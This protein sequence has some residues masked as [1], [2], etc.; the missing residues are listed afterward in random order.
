MEEFSSF[1]DV[2]DKELNTTKT[3]KK[4]KKK[5]RISNLKKGGS[6]NKSSSRC[7]NCD[8]HNVFIDTQISHKVCY[9]C[10][11]MVKF[12]VNN[13]A[14]WRFYGHSDDNKGKDPSRCGMPLDT[15][16]TK[17][18]MTTRV[19]CTNSKYNSLVR[20]QKWQQIH[21]EERPLFIVFTFIDKVLANV[22]YITDD[23]KTLAK[24]YYKILSKPDNIRG[25]LTRG[26]SRKSFIGA[27]IYNAC[28]NLGIPVQ[29]IE[30]AR[31]LDIETSDL[32]RGFKKFAQ[33]EKQKGIQ[34]NKPNCSMLHNYIKKFAN[35]MKFSKDMEDLGH[36]FCLRF[37]KLQILTDQ[38]DLSIV[39]GLLF[40]LT[41]AFYNTHTYKEK[42]M[43]VVNVSGVTLDKVYKVIKENIKYL[44]IGL[45]G[46]FEVPDL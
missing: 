32:T 21:H 40:Y 34:L 13:E 23:A 33:L 10:G 42:I 19:R 31:L 9:D 18:S 6:I 16:L 14:E 27:C 29:K 46:H 28:K 3:Q 12:I 22:E 35:E 5:K 44:Y 45:E 15:L 36:L 39:S 1:F 41:V 7:Q 20:L 2:L 4:S 26:V 30:I 25:T 37:E 8:S 11:N 43:D 24:L 38:N 17:S